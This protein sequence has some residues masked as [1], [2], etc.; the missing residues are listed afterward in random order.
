MYSPEL[1]SI[2]GMLKSAEVK[3]DGIYIPSQLL[4]YSMKPEDLRRRLIVSLESSDLKEHPFTKQVI[5]NPYDHSKTYKCP[6][7]YK[8]VRLK[9]NYC[10]YCGI[11]LANVQR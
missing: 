6:C 2:V 9:D 1:R 8:V 3:K 4:D 10:R 7:C 11:R 5:T